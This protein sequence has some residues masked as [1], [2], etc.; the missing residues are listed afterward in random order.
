MRKTS[1][2][3]FTLI[4][5]LVVIAIIAILAAMLLPALGQAKE[6]AKKMSCLNNMK[7]VGLAN[8]QYVNDWNEYM[9]R[10]SMGEGAGSKD[11]FFYAWLEYMG[12][13]TDLGAAA[14]WKAANRKAL[15]CPSEKYENLS[16]AYDPDGILLTSYY[17]TVSA[18]NAAAI[19]TISQNNQW[20][21]MRPF[22]DSYANE[23]K[24]LGQVSDN[25][26]LVEE[27]FMTSS[28][29]W[30]GFN[31]WYSSCYANPYYA[32]PA[33]YAYAVEHKA[34][35]SPNYY[36]IKSSNFLMK[37]G[38]A[39]SYKLGAITFNNNWIPNN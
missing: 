31:N 34:G 23:G 14:G 32:T 33:G 17:G 28:V 8:F 35:Y 27:K 26:V 11:C 39:R 36:H 38:S 10:A 29:N 4:E 7:Q 24:R 2:T 6:M 25:S 9:P 20:G 1:S 13:K 18:Q 3:P 16:C 22:Y 21:G 12:C 19:A 15:Q 30:F 5:L 37:D